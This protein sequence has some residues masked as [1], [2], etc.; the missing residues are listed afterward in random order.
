MASHHVSIEE[1]EI[2]PRPVGSQSPLKTRMSRRGFL[3]GAAGSALT[4]EAALAD[5]GSIVP[6]VLRIDLSDDATT[7]AVREIPADPNSTRHGSEWCVH[8]AAFGPKA[9]FELAVRGN[10]DASKRLR[11]RNASFGGSSLVRLDFQFEPKGAML[12]GKPVVEHWSVSLTTDLWRDSKKANTFWKSGDIRFADFVSRKNFLQGPPNPAQ[13]KTRF[14]EMFG[15]RVVA[16]E[17]PAGAP[18]LWF[19][20]D[21]VWRIS[22]SD[23]A[24]VTAFGGHASA[25]RF[26]FGWYGLGQGTPFFRGTADPGEQVMLDQPFFRLGE[27]G[28]ASVEIVNPSGLAWEARRIDSP[29]M[30]GKAQTFAKLSFGVCQINLSSEGHKTAEAIRA[31][32]L[33]VTETLLPKAKGIPFAK[34]AVLRHTLWGNVGSRDA[35]AAESGFEMRTLVGRLLVDA[36][37]IKEK[38]PTPADQKK[39][40]SQSGN[41]APLACA[42]G[43]CLETPPGKTQ[44]CVNPEETA[45][46]ADALAAVGDRAG[47]STASIWAVFDRTGESGPSETRRIAIDFNLLG[48]NLSLTDVSHSSL[49]FNSAD[50]RLLYEDGKPFDELKSGE[51]PRASASSYVWVGPSAGDKATIAQFDLS[52]ATLVVAR[53]SDLVKLR[54]RFLDLNLVLCPKPVIRPAHGDCRVIEIEPGKGVFRDDRPVLVAEFDPQHVFE[55]AIFRQN[56]PPP[57]V[58]LDDEKFSRSEII[59]KIAGYDASTPDGLKD[60]VAFRKDVRQRKI[61]AYKKFDSA[62]PPKEDPS[63]EDP[64]Q[65]AAC[66]AFENFSKEFLSQAIRAGLPD[67]QQIYIG[68]F[69]L[70]PDAMALTRQVAQKIGAAT[71]SDAIKAMF[72]RVNDFI[73]NDPARSPRVLAPVQGPAPDDVYF[74]NALRNEAILEQQEPLYGVFRDFY[75]DAR[76][77]ELQPADGSPAQS[78]DQKLV[79]S[80]GQRRSGPGE[81]RR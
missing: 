78:F 69:A 65:K 4:I 27:T 2:Q 14:S 66:E 56:L 24:V 23:G 57:D 46:N 21:C 48:S 59:K 49:S 34:P 61:D 76:I 50:L 26:T 42:P 28:S 79:E 75:R 16:S 17:K 41:A 5:S 36:P 33:F 30:P 40:S 63:K 64:A 72:D 55:E 7:L 54:F 13:L 38:T 51:F 60:L 44:D 6:M 19:L 77:K 74:A 81:K 31:E 80:T 1:E 3:A 53:D 52:R 15:G 71:V 11:V 39:L 32:S 70:D 12:S 62:N 8:A 58:K 37:P 73:K 9:W 47:V 20:P 68:P 67:P 10:S 29:L 35:N 43:P 25:R 22:G 45:Q 18:N